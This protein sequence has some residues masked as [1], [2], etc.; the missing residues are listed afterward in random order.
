ML[1]I[2]HLVNKGTAFLLFLVT[3]LGGMT[4]SE[5]RKER[6]S[7][8]LWKKNVKEGE[9]C[10]NPVGRHLGWGGLTNPL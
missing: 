9:L 6:I 1:V 4:A 10:N 2:Q 8:S 7:N 5:E 3:Q